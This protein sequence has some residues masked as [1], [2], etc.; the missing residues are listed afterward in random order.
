MAGRKSKE[1]K[2]INVVLRIRPESQKE[3]DEGHDFNYME[4][5]TGKGTIAL[6]DKKGRP[7]SFNKIFHPG[8]QNE[9]FE[10]VAKQAVDDAFEGYHGLVFAYGQTGTGKTHTMSNQ[11]PGEEGVLQ[12][13]L[14][15]VFD[16][17]AEDK[18]G[19]Y[20]VKV[21]FIQIYKEVI[22]DLLN[23]TAGGHDEKKGCHLRDDPDCPGL[24]NVTPVKTEDVYRAGTHVS[25]GIKG[26]MRTFLKGDSNRKVSRTEM[27]AVSSRSHTVFTLFINRRSRITEADYTTG[28]SKEELH[29]R[30]ILVDLAGSERQR[31]THAVG[32]RLQEAKSINGSLL[33][34][35]KVIKA[36]TE[37]PQHVPYRESPLT[38]LLQYSLSGQGKTSIIIC[39]GPSHDSKDETRSAI[40][41]GQRAMTIT[42]NAVKHV[43]IDYKAAYFKLKAQMDMRA[44]DAY[45]ATIEE[46]KATHELELE[47]KDDRIRELET[48]VRMMQADGRD[49]GSPVTGAPVG[50]ARG[51]A[52]PPSTGDRP[53]RSSGGSASAAPG[54]DRE[55]RK[56]KERLGEMNELFSV[57]KKEKEKQNGE[58]K[59]ISKERKGLQD[60]VLELEQNLKKEEMEKFMLAK[61]LMNKLMMKDNQID[62]LM[63]VIQKVRQADYVNAAAD[64]CSPDLPTPRDGEEHVDPLANSEGLS[65]EEQIQRLYQCVVKL[66]D[67]RRSMA[68]RERELAAYNTRA[69]DA[70][71]LQAKGKEESEEKAVALAQR[72][73]Q[74]ESRKHQLEGALT[75]LQQRLKGETQ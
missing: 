39:V 17:I 13:A 67:D 72:L 47:E 42:Q 16:R 1:S 28:E 9:I 3:K 62:K 32:E 2:N 35:G 66:R 8:T 49:S 12:R 65:N 26:A 38:R 21:Q 61:E 53:A 54:A 41:F 46:L 74:A 58:L 36:L 22:H 33:V 50:D 4:T 34:L 56:Y 25:E 19:D 43:D 6:D 44:D 5:D 64:V 75:T 59:K 10:S 24:V 63:R 60:Q 15:K 70:I 23:V 57:L 55:I 51:R 68:E 40:E 14:K 11:T 52:T 31:K 48:Q 7:Y 45:A 73:K 71:R 69:K 29:G 27:N 30:L 18:A 20:E 37:P